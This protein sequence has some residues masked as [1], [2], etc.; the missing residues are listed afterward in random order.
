MLARKPAKKKNVDILWT[1]HNIFVLVTVAFS[2]GKN[3][4]QGRF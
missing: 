4:D 1:K 3:F 2:H